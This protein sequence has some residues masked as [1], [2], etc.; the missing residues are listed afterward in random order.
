MPTVVEI[1]L[2]E[3]NE[4]DAQFM[5]DALEEGTLATHIT[6]INNGEDALNYL[7]QQGRHAS[8]PVADLILLDLH[9]PKK[10]GHEVL[11]EIK[12]DA[13]LRRIPIVILSSDT[14]EEVF[15]TAYDLHANC[16]VAKPTDQEEFKLAVKRI[17]AF[18]LRVARRV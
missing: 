5:R 2:V 12:R 11:G 6:W 14:D 18:W 1:L 4:D 15:R 7:H 13:L 16:C 9:L 10:N 17:E 8:P 3:D